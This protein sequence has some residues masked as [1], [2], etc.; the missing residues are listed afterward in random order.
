MDEARPLLSALSTRHP[1]S[2]PLM[3]LIRKAFTM[4][5]HPDTHAEYEARHRPIWPELE[6]TLRDHGVRD[7]S[8][9]LDAGTDTLF[10]YAE[11]EDE[12][13]WEA[14]AETE[15]C[16]RWWASMKPLMP[17]HPDNRPVSSPLRE[18]FRLGEDK[19]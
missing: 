11:I 17:T 5:V 13:Q 18:V 3:P 1:D 10:A 6:Q 19:H 9:F 16:Q 12:S 14:I 4:R 7:Y 2:L 15:V 8:I